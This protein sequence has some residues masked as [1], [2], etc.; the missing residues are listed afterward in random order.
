MIDGELWVLV[1]NAIAMGGAV[2][3]DYADRPYE[4][5]AARVDALAREYAGQV[6][7]LFAAHSVPVEGE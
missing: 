1:R 7:K 3:R 2:E 4:E 5:Y 6:R